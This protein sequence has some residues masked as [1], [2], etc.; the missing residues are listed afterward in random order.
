M[1]LGVAII[2]GFLGAGGV[3][4]FVQFM[5]ARHDTQ[6][7]RLIRIEKKID[8]SLEKS[9]RNEL[10]TTRL[11][12]LFVIQTQSN[13]KDTI[14]RTAHRY[15]IELDGNGEAWD[16]FKHWAESHDVDSSYYNSLLQREKERSKNK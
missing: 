14:L 3:I 7:D 6:N 1:D 15:F 10:A 4:G 16:V 2:S 11:Q 12:L 5:V 8:Q 9:D 13:N